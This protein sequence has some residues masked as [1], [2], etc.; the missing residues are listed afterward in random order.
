[1]LNTKSKSPVIDATVATPCVPLALN[2]A[3]ANAELTRLALKAVLLYWSASR[4]VA[5]IRSPAVTFNGASG[6]I[7]YGRTDGAW[8]A[9]DDQSVSS[10]QQ[11]LQKHERRHVPRMSN[12]SLVTESE[13]E[14]GSFPHV[15][16]RVAPVVAT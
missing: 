6:R 8:T 3:W 7:T 9:T 10:L 12:G 13:F 16:V 15:N 4:T 14:T 5:E 2:G 1:M 11:Q